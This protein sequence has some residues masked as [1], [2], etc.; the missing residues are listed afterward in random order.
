MTRGERS[1]AKGEGREGGQEGG[2]EREGRD[3]MRGFV[4]S[5]RDAGDS[6]SGLLLTSAVQ[7]GGLFRTRCCVA[8]DREEDGKGEGS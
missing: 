4:H 1:A 2:G 5:L 6:H 3:R 7:C 8:K